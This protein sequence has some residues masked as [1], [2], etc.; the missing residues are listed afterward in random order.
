MTS[1]NSQQITV[2]DLMNDA[3][4]NRL[5]N[6]LKTMD[7]IKASGLQNIQIGLGVG[8]NTF[9]VNES[10]LVGMV[11]DNSGSIKTDIKN[12][13]AL[14]C[15]GQN[16]MINA[17]KKSKQKDGILIGTWLINETAPVHPFVT[18]DDAVYLEPGKNYQ[19]GGITPLYRQCCN[20]LSV[21]ALKSKVD[22]AQAGCRCRSIFLVVTD[23]Y[24][25]D[26]D[27]SFNA[28]MVETLIKE[29][30]ETL[31]P[32]FMGISNGS[33]K[34]KT[35]AESMGFYSENIVTPGISESELRKAFQM[36]SQSAAYASQSLANFSKSALGGFIV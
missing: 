34:F 32:Y 7:V 8:S 29:M 14:V 25:I 13:P 22:F 27:D 20:V 28:G 24:N 16:L 10:I 23:G 2:N 3:E 6:D 19:A 15:E 31:I 21:M 9:P 26:N 18:I 4:Q 1:G 30:G 5:F 12:G 33:I 36:V 17:M 35:I 11:I